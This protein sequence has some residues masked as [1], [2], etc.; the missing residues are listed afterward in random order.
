[1][2]DA[3]AGNVG[4][5]RKKIVRERAAQRL[6]VIAEAHLLVKSSPDAL[7]HPT[8]NLAVDDH[9]IEKYTA[10]LDHDI[11]ED[12]DRPSLRIDE[13][14]RRMGGVA[15]RPG[16]ALR[17][18]ARRHLEAAGI[19]FARKILG[20]AVPRAGNLGDWD[21]AAVCGHHAVRQP[22]TVGIGL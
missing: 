9:R 12:G 8:V 3:N 4:R 16:I 14:S 6:P 7:G 20:A 2:D 13:N 10:V 11:V 1:M 22:D 17:L 19:D 5:A 21:A 18:V 15:E